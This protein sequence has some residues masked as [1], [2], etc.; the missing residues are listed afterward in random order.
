MRAAS[1]TRVP[2]RV[3]SVR[4][5]LLVLLLGLG[6]CKAV[7]PDYQPPVPVQ[8]EEFRGAS[9]TAESFANQSWFE[10]FRDPI[11]QELITTA[12][13]ENYDVRSAAERVV[14]ARARYRFID[15]DNYPTI[16][17]VGQ[18]EWTRI[19]GNGPG[20]LPPGVDRNQ[21]LTS[22]G[23]SLNWQLDFW[24]RFDRASEAARADLLATEY[25]RVTVLQSLVIDLAVAYFEL[26]ELDAEL[27]IA[28]RTLASR[29]KSARL[30]QARLDQGVA[31]AVE[32]RQAENLVLTSARLIPITE[33]EIEQTEN[34]IRQLMGG[35][36]GPVPRGTLRTDR[37]ADIDIPAGLPSQLLERRPDIL[38]SEMQL[39][40]ANARI[41]EAKALLYPT[42]EL[43]AFGGGASEDL[44]EVLKAGSGT[45]SILPTVTLPIFNAG[46]LDANVEVT[47]SIQR[48]AALN[49]LSTLQQA[50][51]EVADS[52]VAHEKLR[53][54]RRVQQLI[55]EALTDQLHLS[56]E[57]YRGGVTSYLEVLDTQRDH[58]DAE[59]DLVRSIRDELISTVLL[60]RA[61]G[62]GWQ[63]TS[64]LAATG[65]Q[66]IPVLEAPEGMIDEMAEDDSAPAGAG[67]DTVPGPGTDTGLDT[68]TD[69][70]ADQGD[71]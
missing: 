35:L 59:L 47:E 69:T 41:G 44:D 66:E 45:W 49:Y 10:L 51:R 21:Q 65:I 67:T 56:N 27:V 28:R 31:N 12:L 33:Q 29:E 57:R 37:G 46:R 42:V 40:A 71:D 24:G 55:Q 4:A 23:A 16:D 34:F 70:Q 68:G 25:G 6:A 38:V 13:R 20:G 1:T 36:P 62:G 17:A 11:L 64:D 14:E 43:T 39:I 18:Q 3:A 7:G 8:P 5:L 15:A 60:Y 9:N 22:V 30:V 26:I 53:E 61:L 63:G 48:Q 32:M 2:S 54:V 58:F 50:F 52:L 19:T